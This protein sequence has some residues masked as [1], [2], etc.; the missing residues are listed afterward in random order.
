LPSEQP[1]SIFSPFMKSPVGP[2]KRAVI[3]DLDG[4]LVDSMPLVVAMFSFAVEAFRPRPTPAEIMALLGGP[5]ETCI[6]RLLGMGAADA[7]PAAMVRM[8][9]FERDHSADVAPFE[10]SRELLETLRSAG[11][12]LGI[13]TGRD[14][15]STVSVLEVHGLAPFFGALVCGDDLDSHKPDP[16]GLFRAIEL[17]GVNVEES[18]FVGDSDAD[19]LGGNAAGVHTILVHHGREFSPTVIAL[20]GEVLA[21]TEGAYA[22]VMRLFPQPM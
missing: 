14:R 6:R 12:R 11:V 18:V 4:T 5:P 17:L 21:D 20:A 8:L 13:W 10:G 19:V 15:R 22:A 2:R 16:A 1:P 7:L 3:F 9:R